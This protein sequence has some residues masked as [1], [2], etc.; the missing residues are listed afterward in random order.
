[1]KNKDN[2]I[3]ALGEMKMMRDDEVRDL[4][5]ENDVGNKLIGKQAFLLNNVSNSKFRQQVYSLRK[6][7]S[8]PE[9]NLKTNLK[10]NE[11]IKVDINHKLI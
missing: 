1:M 5:E 2:A 10:D 7:F 4:K 11:M 9:L 3:R 6:C 8:D